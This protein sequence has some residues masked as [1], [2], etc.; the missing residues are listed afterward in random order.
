M[1]GYVAS[2]QDVASI[3]CYRADTPWPLWG[4]PRYVASILSSES[5]EISWQAL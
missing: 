3:G 5:E 1:Y 2:P 4:I